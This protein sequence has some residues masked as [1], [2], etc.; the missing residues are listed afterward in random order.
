GDAHLRL[1][2]ALRHDVDVHLP[3]LAHQLVDRVDVDLGEIHVHAALAQACLQARSGEAG[4]HRPETY[5]V[6][7]Q[8]ERHAN[9][10]LTAAVA[11]V[12]GRHPGPTRVLRIVAGPAPGLGARDAQVLGGR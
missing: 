9:R 6:A 5:A 12:S 2:S 3:E 10:D 4:N 8:R 7:D 11:R 1:S